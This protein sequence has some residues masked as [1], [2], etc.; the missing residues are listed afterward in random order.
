MD[1]GQ[2]DPTRNHAIIHWF[3]TSTRSWHR[4][5]K[6]FNLWRT[7]YETP[8]PE[9]VPRILAKD[10][11]NCIEKIRDLVS[12]LWRIPIIC[13]KTRKLHKQNKEYTLISSIKVMRR[14]QGW[15]RLTIRRSNKTLVICSW[16]TS[17]YVK[18][19]ISN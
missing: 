4:F 10:K 16:I 12:N 15:G 18:T 13:I 14:P 8:V 3:W 9:I 5:K 17:C 19:R 2:S 7:S 1:N 6:F 11:K